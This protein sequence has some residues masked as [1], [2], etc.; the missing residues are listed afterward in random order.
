MILRNIAQQILRALSDTPVVL[1]TGARQTGKSTLVQWLARGPHPA[2]YLTLDDNATLAAATTDPAG[3]LAELDGP[4]IL[5]EVQRA[6]GLFLPLK[7]EVDRNRQPGRFLL[8]GSANVLML[9]RL[10][11]SLAGRMEILSLWPFSQGEI[12]SH[13][14]DFIDAVFSDSWEVIPPPGAGSEALLN[15]VLSGGYPEILERPEESRRAAWFNSYLTTLFQRDVRD[16]ASIEHAA[17]MPRLLALLASRTAGLLNISDI[18]RS[19]GIPHSTL[20]RY[21]A[22]LEAAFIYHPLLPW[23]A[24]V[25]RRLVKAPKVMLNDTGLV[26]YLN[27]LSRELLERDPTRKGALWESF[28]AAELTKQAS[29]SEVRRPRVF[30]FRAYTGQEVDLVIEDASGRVVGVE[31]KASASVAAGDLRGLGFFRDKLG[32]RFVRGV[33]LYLGREAVPFGERLSAHPMETLWRSRR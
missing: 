14:E 17:A 30:H 5:D 7:T 6:P 27:G 10:S 29:W 18:S 26:S 1:L 2:R 3:F 16:L 4:V 22:V 32:D 12:E 19:L 31:V 8:T 11:E 15:R 28:V 9:P 25:G 23:F 21:V 20:R 13:Q 33:L 24:D